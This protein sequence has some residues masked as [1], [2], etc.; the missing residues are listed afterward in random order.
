MEA[1]C[2]IVVAFFAICI[3]MEYIENSI[4]EEK[5]REAERQRQEYEKQEKIKSFKN[6]YQ[7]YKQNFENQ[8]G[9]FFNLDYSAANTYKELS[10]W[11]ESMKKVNK[12]LQ[13]LTG[14][15][16]YSTDINHYVNILN[17]FQ[18]LK[19]KIEM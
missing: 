12:D 19:N 7:N 10:S 2:L 1:C 3:G 5:K 13:S 16:L 17:K 18:T 15:A 6:C 8:L 11:L 4:K 9:Q 14:K